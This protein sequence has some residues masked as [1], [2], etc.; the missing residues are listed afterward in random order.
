MSNEVRNWCRKTYEEQWD[1]PNA[2]TLA[3]IEETVTRY[4]IIHAQYDVYRSEQ[5]EKS[6]WGFRT[7]DEY[8]AL[9]LAIEQ[10]EQALDKLVLRKYICRNKK[11][12]RP[13]VMRAVDKEYC[14]HFYE[15]QKD[16]PNALPLQE[17][18]ERATNEAVMMRAERDYFDKHD[19]WTEKR[20]DDYLRS[21]EYRMIYEVRTRVHHLIY[22]IEYDTSY[23]YVERFWKDRHPNEPE[24]VYTIEDYY[25][26]PYIEEVEETNTEEVKSIDNEEVKEAIPSEKVEAY[27]DLELW[28]FNGN[29]TAGGTK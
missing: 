6:G 24:K 12:N 11:A 22:E 21:F 19:C 17:I 8:K 10:S 26:A 20:S 2:M 18:M 4:I 9:D 27:N 7:T 5:I 23:H 3:E 25:E 16:K 28:N 1:M 13:P 29:Q 15:F 14:E